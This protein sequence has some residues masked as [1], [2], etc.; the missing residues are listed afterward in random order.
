MD[1]LTAA[2]LNRAEFWLFLTTLIYFLMNGAQVFETLVFVPKWTDAPPD[3]FKLLLDG[4]GASLKNFW[5][6]FHSLHEVSFLLAIVFCWKLDFARNWILILFAIHFAVRVWTLV[7]FAPNIINFQKIAAAQTTV[8]DL[9]SRTSVWKTLNYL[10]VAI[11]IGVSIGMA[12]VC[13]RMFSL[14]H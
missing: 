10:R 11:F 5:I 14:R 1:N 2:Y 13:V 7:Y 4:R 12:A 8:E 3:N 6:V 9:M